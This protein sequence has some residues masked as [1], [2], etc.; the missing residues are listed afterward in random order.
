MRE[1][2][3]GLYRGLT[4]L[5]TGHWVLV[6]L[7][8]EYLIQLD[9][10]Y[11]KLVVNTLLFISLSI[12]LSP[13]PIYICLSN[14]VPLIS[15][16]LFSFFLSLSLCFCLIIDKLIVYINIHVPVHVIYIL[17][18]LSLLYKQT[19][20]VYIYSPSPLQTNSFEQLCI[21][22][23]NE[24]LQQLFNHTMFILEQVSLTTVIIPLRLYK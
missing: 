18:S 12:S 14:C 6:H 10:K 2:L 13:L 8:L 24:K 3:S 7:S 21:N 15:F 1:C 22:Y 23:T 4:R 19:N 16:S 5:Q 20:C 9:L 11:L 17:Y